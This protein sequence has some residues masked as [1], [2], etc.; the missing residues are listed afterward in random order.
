MLKRKVHRSKSKDKVS[1]KRK[2][3]ERRNM[4]MKKKKVRKARRQ[5]NRCNNNK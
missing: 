5:I 4:M 2:K 1:K 3:M